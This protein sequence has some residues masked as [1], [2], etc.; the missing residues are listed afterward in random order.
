MNLKI[1]TWIVI[2]FVVIP[3]AIYSIPF[4]IL[5]V[6][7]LLV[8]ISHDPLGFF[9]LIFTTRPDSIWNPGNF[10]HLTPT[11][12]PLGTWG[13]ISMY[14]ISVF[15]ASKK[16][17]LINK[18]YIYFGLLAGTLCSLQIIMYSW[19]IT[20]TKSL[21]YGWPIIAAIFYSVLLF[22]GAKP[23]ANSTP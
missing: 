19:S 3:T 4:L 21:Y 12:V 14:E 20:G 2:I 11:A 1:P 15:Y 17:H 23:I 16:P 13:L 9:S 22:T 5:G 10:M 6:I 8:A 18:K 7:L